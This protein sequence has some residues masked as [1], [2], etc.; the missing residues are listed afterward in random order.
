MNEYFERERERES[1][2]NNSYKKK[3]KDKTFLVFQDMFVKKFN[4]NYKKNV[5]LLLRGIIYLIYEEPQKVFKVI[6]LF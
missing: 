6:S 5:N 4:N 3:A 1:F 2:K